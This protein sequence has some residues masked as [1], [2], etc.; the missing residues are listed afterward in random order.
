MIWILIITTL[1]TGLTFHFLP[2]WQRRSLFFTLSVRPEFPLT[3]AAKQLTRSYRIVVWVATI[4]TVILGLL[5]RSE[6]ALAPLIVG[7]T[8]AAMGA[9]SWVRSKVERLEIEGRKVTSPQL[10]QVA[11][12]NTEAPDLPGSWF[13][14]LFPF[15]LFAIV[16]WYLNANWDRIPDKFPVH[17]D[18]MGKANRWAMKSAKSVYGLLVFGMIMQGML[19]MLFYGLKEGTRRS[20]PGGSRMR[21]LEVNLWLMLAVQWVTAGMFVIIALTP[22]GIPFAKW[23][24]AGLSFGLAIV[25][26][27]SIVYMAKIQRDPDLAE[28][29]NTPDECWRWGGQ[30][31]YNPNDSAMMVEKRMGLGY[32]FNFGHRMSWVFLV[33]TALTMVLPVFLFN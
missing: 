22:L 11:P 15:A 17:W 4:L 20:S 14:C 5:V 18:A 23:G 30:V 29:D 31:Y 8:V 26:I 24:I 33:F 32:T 7:Q 2:N 9:F 19:T 28:T 1:L 12:L 27:G 16:A 13:A 21:F 3:S 25:V 10:P 6:T